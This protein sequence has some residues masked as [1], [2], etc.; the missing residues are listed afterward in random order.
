[1]IASSKAVHP[2]EICTKKLLD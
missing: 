2:K 1:K